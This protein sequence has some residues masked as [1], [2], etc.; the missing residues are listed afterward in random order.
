[1]GWTHNALASS[2]PSASASLSAVAIPMQGFRSAHLSGK[3]GAQRDLL[4]R[5]QSN[6]CLQLT[7][8][9]VLLPATE[10][11]RDQQDARRFIA[12]VK[13]HGRFAFIQSVLPFAPPR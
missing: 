9:P 12:R 6:Q 11:T 10:A 5:I 1:M 3:P 13:S 4:L 2:K 7:P 8:G